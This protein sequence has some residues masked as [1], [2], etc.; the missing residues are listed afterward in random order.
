MFLK[1]TT[2]CYDFG[3]PKETLNFGDFKFLGIISKT[4][5]LKGYSIEVRK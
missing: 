5:L 1:E 4:F 3:K 2:F